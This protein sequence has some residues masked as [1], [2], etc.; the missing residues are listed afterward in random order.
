MT[1]A[2]TPLRVEALHT[3][4]LLD[5][6]PEAA[7]AAIARLAAHCTSAPIGVVWLV[8]GREQAFCADRGL[9]GRED[10]WR[11][12]RRLVAGAAAAGRSVAVSDASAHGGVRHGEE[13]GD[14]P[15][16]AY[17][18]V[19]ITTGEGSVQG[20][21]LTASV[22]A[23]RWSKEHSADL[24]ALAR[25]AATQL[26]VRRVARQ[27]LSAQR[28]TAARTQVLLEAEAALRDGE[29]LHRSVVEALDEGV[30]V[31][32]A[33]G[34]AIACNA[35]ATR[36]LGLD[37]ARILGC[38]P[39]FLPSFFEDGAV[40]DAVT[41]PTRR[42]LLGQ[43]QR[44]TVMRIVRP[45]GDERWLSSNYQL[46]PRGRDGAPS[47]VVSFTDITQRRRGEQALRDSEQ[48]LRTVVDGAVG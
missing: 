33:H 23:R 8:D 27:S 21:V 24:E 17:A 18:A 7:L 32:D 16:L 2:V 14:L 44:H 31:L 1:A 42:A 19:P 45:D 43:P 41:T 26:E 40:V 35:S 38:R 11:L 4:T 22:G 20:V 47:L 36:I 34:A 39:P 13:R 46:L 9:E 6:R 15:L 48:R 29:A 28:E 3:A 12:A 5:A 25:M 37:A 30:V 10:V